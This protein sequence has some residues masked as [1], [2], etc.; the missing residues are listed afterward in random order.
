MLHDKSYLRPPSVFGNLE[1]HKIELKEVFMTSPFCENTNRILSIT[2]KFLDE[3]KI[4]KTHVP[5][6]TQ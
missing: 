4:V 2:T 1:S 6:F 5:S 3:T